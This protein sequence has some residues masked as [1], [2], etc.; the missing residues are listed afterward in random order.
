MLIFRID[1]RCLRRQAGSVQATLDEISGAKT[2]S[3]D[4][5][6]PRAALQYRSL[7]LYR[8]QAL[9]HRVSLV[10]YPVKVGEALRGC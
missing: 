10:L 5:C 6:V 2:E 7:K 8:L 1:A 3:L 9:V 4:S